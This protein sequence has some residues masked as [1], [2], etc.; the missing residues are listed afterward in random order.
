MKLA[1]ASGAR[2]AIAPPSGAGVH[3]VRLYLRSLDPRLPRVVWILQAGELA[4]AF[5]LGVVMPFLII[6]L[7]DVRGIS[8][9]TAGLAAAANG[10]GAMPAGAASGVLADRFGPKRVVVWALL[11]ETIAIAC[12]PFIRAGWHALVLDLV[13][14]AGNG[15]FWTSESSL[16]ALLTPE[17]RRHAA[18]AQERATLN[19]GIGLGGLAGGAIAVASRPGTFSILFAI[20]ALT[21]LGFAG[22]LVAR[23]PSPPLAR[24][25]GAGDSYRVVLRDRAF[26]ALLALNTTLIAAGIVPFVEFLPVYA[27]HV[28]GVHEGAIGLVFFANTMAVVLLQLSVA[29][30]L[31][32][33][34]RMPAL[35]L[36]GALWAGVWLVVPAAVETLAAPSAALVLAGAAIVLGAG[37]CMHGAVHGALVAELA[38]PALLGRYMALSSLSWQLAFVIGPALGGAVLDAHPVALWLAAAG[39]CALAA[40]SALVLERVLPA[41]L[42]RT[43][44]RGA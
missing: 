36:M 30:A 8:L 13:L 27:K 3:R 11:V 40:A 21:F 38:A 41:R 20:D 25:D 18:F 28:A 33:R 6:Y 19:L 4:Y 7:H 15:A 1:R 39:A 32:G 37:E 23:V 34:R 26:V 24:R 43:P 16:L 22:L 29:R 14:G 17:D 35:A 12:F 2:A 44:T 10:L 5:G 42:R 9:T 31:E